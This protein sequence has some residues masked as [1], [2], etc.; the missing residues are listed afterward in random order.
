MAEVSNLDLCHDRHRVENLSQ[1]QKM[2]SAVIVIR[3]GITE[4][5]VS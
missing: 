2:W 3:K 4:N 5:F 1:M